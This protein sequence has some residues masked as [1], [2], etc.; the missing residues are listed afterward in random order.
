MQRESLVRGA[1]LKHGTD[2]E[3]EGVVMSGLVV[4]PLTLICRAGCHHNYMVASMVY[5]TLILFQGLE[6]LIDRLEP[7]EDDEIMAL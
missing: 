3:N 5:S 4:R 2:L 7:L 1:I 6:M